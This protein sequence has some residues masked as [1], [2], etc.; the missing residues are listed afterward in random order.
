MA[1]AMAAAAED[2]REE[3]PDEAHGGITVLY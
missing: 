2:E 3:W 1:R